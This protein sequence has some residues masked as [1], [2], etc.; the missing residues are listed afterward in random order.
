M[1]C[2]YGMHCVHAIITGGGFCFTFSLN[3]YIQPTISMKIYPYV[4]I[5]GHVNV[6]W[7]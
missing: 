4:K 5:A 3:F 1:K 6:C 7:Y 2:I